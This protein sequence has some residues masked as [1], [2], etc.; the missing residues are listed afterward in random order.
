MW[1]PCFMAPEIAFVRF[2]HHC[3]KLSPASPPHQGPI[4]LG[5]AWVHSHYQGLP[6]ISLYF[7]KSCFLCTLFAGFSECLGN[8]TLT[9]VTHHPCT[10][11]LLENFTSLGWTHGPMWVPAKKEAGRGNCRVQVGPGTCHDRGGKAPS[12]FPRVT[13]LP[14]W[15]K[16]PVSLSASSRLLPLAF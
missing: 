13:S 1:V 6:V 15:F 2:L 4:V 8:K 12:C 3:L 10:L 7:C 5:P 11:T 14:A 16:F 9:N